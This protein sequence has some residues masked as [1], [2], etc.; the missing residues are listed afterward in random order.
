MQISIVN[1]RASSILWG[2]KNIRFTSQSLIRRIARSGHPVDVNSFSSS[3]RFRELLETSTLDE[4]YA[5]TYTAYSL[6]T[7]LL[8]TG[9]WLRNIDK[10][11]VETLYGAAGKA[12]LMKYMKDSRTP[13][14]LQD[15]DQVL[16]HT[17]MSK[18]I[19]TSFL[20]SSL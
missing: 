2:D 18:E 6:I 8:L 4:E 3:D 16:R 12:A 13:P 17:V 10:G 11:A 14:T 19:L 5:V 20:E 1:G 9:R 15:I 7:C